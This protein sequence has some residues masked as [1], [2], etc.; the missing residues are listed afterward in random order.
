MLDL[1]IE[2]WTSHPEY[3][4]FRTLTCIKKLSFL[5]KIMNYC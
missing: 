3:G 2:K 4:C 1:T 5:K